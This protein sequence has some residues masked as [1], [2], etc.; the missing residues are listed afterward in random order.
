MMIKVNG[1]FTFLIFLIFVLSL[2]PFELIIA[3]AS[4]V[5]EGQ[6]PE[7][8]EITVEGGGK[9]TNVNPAGLAMM[10][11]GKDF[12]LINVHVPYEGEIEK[13]DLF[14]PYNE[15]EQNMDKLPSN[16]KTKIILYCKT[17]RMSDIAARILIKLGYTNI[18]NLDGGMIRWEKAGYPLVY[19]GR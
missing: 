7:K 19:R 9:Y 18:W 14:I 11:K 8:Q 10:L 2:N 3:T 1:V 5:A 16:K 17:N 13:T 6:I 15:I 12:L 4:P